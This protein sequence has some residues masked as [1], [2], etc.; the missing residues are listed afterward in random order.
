MD[1]ERTSLPPPVHE[2]ELFRAVTV[3]TEQ[4]DQGGLSSKLCS[5]TR[6]SSAP[7][8]LLGTLS[9]GSPKSEKNRF[10]KLSGPRSQV[11]VVEPQTGLK[12]HEPRPSASLSAINI[13]REEHDVFRLVELYSKARLSMDIDRIPTPTKKGG[14]TCVKAGYVGDDACGKTCSL[15]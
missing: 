7:G 3:L 5:H 15:M 8:N 12:F 4:T 13:A 6:S 2:E 10:W 14:K 9:L 11:N 1:Q